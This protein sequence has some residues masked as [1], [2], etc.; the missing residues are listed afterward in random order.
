MTLVVRD[1][2]SQR[3]ALSK[4]A[5]T[6]FDMCQ[7]ASWYD[8]HDRKP[9]IPNERITFG[10]AVDAAVEM[11]VKQIRDEGNVVMARVMDAVQEVV[12]RDETEVNVDEVETAAERFV[13]EFA[14]TRSWEGVA[15]QPNII[16]NLPDLG[17]ISTHPDLVYA[18]NDVDD[19][20]TSKR[21]K[22]DEPTLELGFYALAVEA[23]DGRPVERVGYLTWVRVTRPY[24]QAISFPVTDELKRWT[25]ERAGAYIRAKKADELLNRKADIPR[26]FS[27]PGGPAF[28]SMCDGCQ[29]A[30][31]N[32][33]ECASAFRS[34]EVA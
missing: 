16:V 6:Q 20:K 5:L 22:A 3:T 25:R 14:G 4:S 21:A 11:I 7:T 31:A 8:L 34:E 15:T 18:N 33:G 19:V 2:L 32:G 28:R 9:L 30:P 27:F 10:S 13:A 23:F 26:N 29:Y 17:E 24:W 1:D 12:D